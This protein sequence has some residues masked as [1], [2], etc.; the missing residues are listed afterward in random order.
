MFV[1]NV[2]VIYLHTTLHTRHQRETYVGY[3]LSVGAKW[4]FALQNLYL[5]STVYYHT[6]LFEIPTLGGAGK[7]HTS[8]LCMAAVLA[9]MVGI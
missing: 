8:K 5:V 1:Q 3:R 7:T 4:C 6:I 2:N 9:F